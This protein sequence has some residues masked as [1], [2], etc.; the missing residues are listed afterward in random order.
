MLNI[1]YFIDFFLLFPTKYIYNLPENYVGM[2]WY[3]ITLCIEW[4]T[5]FIIVTLW[6]K[7]DNIQGVKKILYQTSGYDSNIQNKKYSSNKH[8]P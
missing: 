6:K 8:M 2:R 5:Y 4:I 7:L 1:R 3:I